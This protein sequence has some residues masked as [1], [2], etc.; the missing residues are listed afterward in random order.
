MLENNQLIE[1]DKQIDIASEKNR[2]IER[3]NL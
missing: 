2:Q 1:L 3:K